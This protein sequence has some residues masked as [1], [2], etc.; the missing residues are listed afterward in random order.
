MAVC[1]RRLSSILRNMMFSSAGRV[2]AMR[3]RRW[4]KSVEGIEMRL[5]VSGICCMWL[6]RVEHRRMIM[7]DATPKNNARKRATMNAE[8]N[9]RF[10]QNFLRSLFINGSRIRD[11]KKARM[12]GQKIGIMY[13][14]VSNITN[15]DSNHIAAFFNNE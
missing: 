12:N 6:P 1:S 14:V 13:L 2:E 10:I 5:S 9:P 11:M 4:G 15:A 7:T 8:A 3:S